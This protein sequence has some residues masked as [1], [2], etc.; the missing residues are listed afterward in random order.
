MRWMAV[1]LVLAGCSFEHGTLGAISLDAP[2]DAGPAHCLDG[3]CLR[4]PIQIAGA[5]VSGPQ[6][7]FVLLVRT[8]ADPELAAASTTGE[9]FRFTTATGQPLPYERQRYVPATG[10]LIAWV[11]LPMLPAADTTLY[12]YYGKAGV[13][14]QQDVTATWGASYAGVWHLDETSTST[15]AAD[16]SGNHNTGTALNVFSRLAA[17]GPT[18]GAAGAIGEAVTFDGADD[19]LEMP[20]S[21]S[22]SATTGLATFALW[23]K[24]TS[25][26]AADYQ[27][28]LS[29]SNRFNS[30][31]NEDGYEWAAQPAGDFFLYAW[32]GREDYNL[33]PNPFTAGTWQYLVATL[34]FS[35]TSVKIY[36]DA[37]PMMFTTVNESAWSSKGDPGNWCWGANSNPTAAGP[38]GG[39]MDEIRVMHGAKDASWIATSYANQ[40]PDSTMV[41]IGA[42]QILEP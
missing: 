9:D 25:L 26:T 30:G 34:D 4:K 33:G 38:F 5:Q 29:S 17:G 14:D 32:G 11:K 6:Q 8:A 27:R 39:G 21:T 3:W 37:Q 1:A 12:L 10:E 40:R 20:K 35:T 23:I 15:T 18:F 36:V 7:D 2:V 28:V 31:V 41:T 42:Q 19:E 16:A 22:L 13:T 24:W